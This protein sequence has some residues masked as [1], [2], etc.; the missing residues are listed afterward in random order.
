VCEGLVGFGV[1]LER[2]S[3]FSQKTQY[4]IQDISECFE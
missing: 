3:V 4:G 1:D 2:F